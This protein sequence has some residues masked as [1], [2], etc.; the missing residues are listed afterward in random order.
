MQNK[1]SMKGL[2]S[3]VFFSVRMWIMASIAVAIVLTQRVELKE[4]VL[5]QETLVL[6]VQGG[7]LTF[8]AFIS[9]IGSYSVESDREFRMDMI[10][11]VIVLVGASC[12]LTAIY[13][14]GLGEYWLPLGMLAMAVFFAVIDFMF[15]LTGGSSKLL[16]MDKNRTSFEQG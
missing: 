5:G 3:W 1:N 12:S 6:L 16:E 4:L 2:K 11:D 7:I 15:S 13:C 9:L 10:L 8:S 14:L